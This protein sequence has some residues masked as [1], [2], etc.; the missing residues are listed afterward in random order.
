[1]FND[2]LISQLKVSFDID[3]RESFGISIVVLLKIKYIN[4]AETINIRTA[5]NRNIFLALKYF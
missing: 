4:I 5:Q 2:E 1:M 3:K